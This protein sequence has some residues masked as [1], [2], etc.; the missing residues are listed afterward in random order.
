MSANIIDGKAFAASVRQKVA[1]KVADLKE[2]HSI[3]PVSYTH[4][5][6]HET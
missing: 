4:L 3:T 2:A 5:R 1:S 6:A